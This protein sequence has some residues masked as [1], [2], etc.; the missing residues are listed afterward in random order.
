ML[1]EACGDLVVKISS[2]EV[3]NSMAV[4][5]GEDGHWNLGDILLSKDADVWAT[6]LFASILWRSI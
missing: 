2:I 4:V 6:L 3:K 5:V 1:H